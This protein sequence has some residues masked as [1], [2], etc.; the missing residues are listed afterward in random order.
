[1][2]LTKDQ[3]LPGMAEV[4]GMEEVVVVATVEVAME[5]VVVM[6]AVTKQRRVSCEKI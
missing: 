4:V 3:V 1:M 6:V 2:L 5:Q